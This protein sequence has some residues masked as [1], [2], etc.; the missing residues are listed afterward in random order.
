MKT[1]IH[2]H[3]SNITDRT[4]VDPRSRDPTSFPLPLRVDAKPD[5]LMFKDTHH[6]ETIT[7]LCLDCGYVALFC[8]GFRDIDRLIK[9]GK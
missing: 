5:A 3:G 9:V 2:C 8:P 4:F 7:Y 6:F 1:C